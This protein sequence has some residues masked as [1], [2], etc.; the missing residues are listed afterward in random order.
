MRLIGFVIDLVLVIIAHI[1][2]KLITQ[3]LTDNSEIALNLGNLEVYI[4]KVH[5]RRMKFWYHQITIRKM[6]FVTFFG[7]L[8]YF[9]EDVYFLA[10]SETK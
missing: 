1:L 4:K 3:K 6:V 9:I 7:Q 10:K 8:L 2:H 5:D